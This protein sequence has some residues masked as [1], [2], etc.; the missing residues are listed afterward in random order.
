MRAVLCLL[1]L[2]L[3]ASADVVVLKS[4]KKLHGKVVAEDPE[5]VLNIYN[6]GFPEMTL[7]VQRFPKARVK[8]VV[9]TIP[10][11]AQEFQQRIR[12]AEDAEACVQLAEW[13]EERKLKRERVFAL[14]KALRLEPGHAAARKALGARAPKGDL[15]QFAGPL[16]HSR[17]VEIPEIERP[18]R[19]LLR[20][21]HAGHPLAD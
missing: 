13:C 1:L 10:S 5:V 7:D 2:P 14:E 15:E 11:P 3:L 21:V 9:R 8:S 18:A 4:G 17:Q 19:D 6:S 20:A 16:E 12:A